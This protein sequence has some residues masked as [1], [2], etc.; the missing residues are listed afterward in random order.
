MR[1]NVGHAL[2]CPAVTHSDV[3][4]ELKARPSEGPSVKN[5][6]DDYTAAAAASAAE[7][8]PGLGY[9]VNNNNI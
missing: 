5:A 8:K 9:T 7:T 6:T 4:Y 1:D 3:L 2:Y